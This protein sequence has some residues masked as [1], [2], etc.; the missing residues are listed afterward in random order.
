MPRPSVKEKLVEYAESVFR[1]KGFNGASVQDITTAAGVPKG[2]FYNHFQSKQELAAEIVRRYCDA[3]DFS[4]LGDTGAREHTALERIR[5]HFAIQAERTRATGV[6]YGCLLVTM[7]SDSPTSGDEVR[8]AVQEGFDGWTCALA[9]LIEGA[10]QAGQIASARR[11]AD[12]AAFLIDAFEGGALRG[13]AT[14][15]H[16]ASMRALDIALDALRP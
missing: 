7:A 5:V 9:T 6:G 3:T 2:S 12:L 4:M 13:K 14:D 16:T 10:Q 15:D 11:A 1:R 8:S